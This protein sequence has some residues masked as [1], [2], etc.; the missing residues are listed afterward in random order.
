[1]KR[2]WLIFLFTF[3]VINFNSYA[4]VA[5]QELISYTLDYY[6]SGG[7]I[8]E[9]LFTQQKIDT[10]RPE[11]AERKQE[12]EE[13][14][15]AERKEWVLVNRTKAFLKD[16][17]PYTNINAEH[18]SNLYFV[19]TE[20]KEDFVTTIDAG[21]KFRSKL[22]KNKISLYLDGG[23]E[24]IKYASQTVQNTDHPYARGILKADLGKLG[25]AFMTSVDKSRGTASILENSNISRFIDSWQYSSGASAKF[26]LKRFESELQYNRF[27]TSYLDEQDSPSNNNTQILATR[28]TYRIFPR[29]KLFLEYAHGWLYYFKNASSTWTYDRYWSG[30]ESRILRKFFGEVKY[31]YIASNP[32]TGRHKSGNTLSM[33]LNYVPSRRLNVY[34]QVVNGVGESDLL[35][36]TLDKIR[37]VFFGSSYF[38]F[39]NEKLRLQAQIGYKEDDLIDSNPNSRQKYFNFFFRPEYKLKKWLTVGLNY[40]YQERRCNVKS[41]EYIDNRVAFTLDSEF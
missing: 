8:D 33:K 35:N 24:I 39:T 17:H 7:K 32:K 30:F 3:T 37:G 31:G 21:L 12:I 28:N 38:P 6:N 18:H 11:S 16:I 14:T 4:A 25:L 9:K 40:T 5:R 27:E 13:V 29:T 15:P 2:L 1:M 36:N 41:Q 22:A 20:A 19:H 26:K 10:N 23:D 34:T